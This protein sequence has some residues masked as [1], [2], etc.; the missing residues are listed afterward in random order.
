M[1]R[2]IIE[3]PCTWGCG[4]TWPLTGH[5]GHDGGQGMARRIHEER[6]CPRLICECGHRVDQ[7][8]TGEGPWT[9]FCY[10]L[11]E[12]GQLTGEACQCERPTI[13]GKEVK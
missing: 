6:E 8:Q 7:H 10:A 1:G 3:M 2:T 13:D 12:D 9:G 11:P 5:S 4:K